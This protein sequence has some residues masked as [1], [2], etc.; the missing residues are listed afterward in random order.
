MTAAQL[1][2]ELESNSYMMFEASDALEATS[3]RA[4]GA[5]KDGVIGSKVS[6]YG[7]DNGADLDGNPKKKKRED[8]VDKAKLL[9]EDIDNEEDAITFHA[10]MEERYDDVLYNGGKKMDGE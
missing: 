1:K 3:G 2:N 9:L 5:L 4:V 6:G 7:R 8:V 10:L